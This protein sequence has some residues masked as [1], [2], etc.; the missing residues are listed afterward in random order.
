[1][2]IGTRV[3][4]Q[5]NIARAEQVCQIN[6]VSDQSNAVQGAELSGLLEEMK[7]FDLRGI[8]IMQTFWVYKSRQSHG[9][10]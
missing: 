4:E 6:R 1:M 7:P 8:F 9:L 3:S 2:V 5:N 10:R